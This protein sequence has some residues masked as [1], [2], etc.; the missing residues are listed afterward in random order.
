MVLSD[1]ERVANRN[2]KLKPN[3]YDLNNDLDVTHTSHSLNS[4]EGLIMCSLYGWSVVLLGN[5]L[6]EL[7]KGDTRSLDYSSY[8]LRSMV[9]SPPTLS[10]WVLAR[11]VDTHYPMGPIT[12]S[13]DPTGGRR[14]TSSA[15]RRSGTSLVS[16]PGAR[17]TQPKPKTMIF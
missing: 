6:V 17:G 11:A 2:P 10:N 3:M 13:L 16:L 7:I 14:I 15:V 8:V 5:N 12:P 4:L 9:P 1:S